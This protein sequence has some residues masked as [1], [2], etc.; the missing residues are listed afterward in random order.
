MGIIVVIVA[1]VLLVVFG[2][3]ENEDISLD[4][5]KAGWIQPGFVIVALV[6]TGLAIWTY[7]GVKYYEMLNAQQGNKNDVQYGRRFLMIRF[8]IFA[9]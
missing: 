4:E 1:S 5:F 9:Y 6:L 8:I 2:P 7:S 3:N